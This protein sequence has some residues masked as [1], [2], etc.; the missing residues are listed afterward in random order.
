[1]TDEEIITSITFQ[2]QKRGIEP[3]QLLSKVRAYG[4]D[5]LS[6]KDNILLGVWHF[7]KKQIEA[8]EL[9]RIAIENGVIEI[10]IPLSIG[11]TGYFRYE[12]SCQMKYQ[13]QCGDKTVKIELTI[14]EHNVWTC[15]ECGQVLALRNMAASIEEDELE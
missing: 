4:R 13:G 11:E 15:P 9:Y 14:F 12:C 3:E 10:I 6:R 2:F 7:Y 5:I 8:R 1:M